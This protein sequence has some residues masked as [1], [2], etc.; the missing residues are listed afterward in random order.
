VPLDPDMRKT[1]ADELLRLGSP[2]LTK[3]RERKK[4]NAEQVRDADWIRNS[5][6][7]LG[8][9]VP[10]AEQKVLETTGKTYEAWRKRGAYSRK[11]KRKNG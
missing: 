6:R 8:C 4:R 9:T 1:L 5:F 7:R 11:A 3:E 2:N 10:E